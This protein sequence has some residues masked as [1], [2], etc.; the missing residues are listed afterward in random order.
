MVYLGPELKGTTL[1]AELC[2]RWHSQKEELQMALWHSRQR[3]PKGGEINIDRTKI[4][5][6]D[7]SGHSCSSGFESSLPRNVLVF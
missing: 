3:Q 5:D 4:A 2:S 6:I 1:K 7:K